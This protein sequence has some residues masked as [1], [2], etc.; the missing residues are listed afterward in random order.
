MAKGNNVLTAGD[1]A[2][3]CNVAP[4]TVSQWVD[5]GLLTGER[6]P[7]GA[8]DGAWLF[9]PQLYVVGFV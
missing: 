7:V 4:R 8:P 9:S 3:I 5:R 1:V 6:I 2:N